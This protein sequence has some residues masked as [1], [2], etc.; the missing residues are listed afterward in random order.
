MTTPNTGRVERHHR[1]KRNTDRGPGIFKTVLQGVGGGIAALLV[2]LLSLPVLIEL[3]QP[4][5]ILSSTAI[6]ASFLLLWF[7]LWTVMAIT[8]EHVSGTTD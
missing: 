4:L 8:F 2:V 3:V 6:V 7:T 5:E 1:G